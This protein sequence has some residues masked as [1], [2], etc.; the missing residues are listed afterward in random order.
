MIPPDPA[1]APSLPPLAATLDAAR[2]QALELDAA[3]LLG[4]LR[5]R[6]RLPRDADGRPRTYLAGQSLGAQ[7]LGAGAALR[8]ELDQWARTAHRWAQ[9]IM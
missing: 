9:A 3:D 7:P 1:P 2:D 4:G 5:S 6:F 8:R